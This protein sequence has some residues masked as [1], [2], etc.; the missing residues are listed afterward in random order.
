[1]ELYMLLCICKG[2]SQGLITGLCKNNRGG[3]AI[4]KILQPSNYYKYKFMSLISPKVD[5]V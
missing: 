1:M 5:W 3:A 2:I 4:V